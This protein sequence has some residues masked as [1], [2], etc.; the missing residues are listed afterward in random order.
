[1]VPLNKVENKGREAELDGAKGLAWNM[2]RCG[3]A[4]EKYESMRCRI[5]IQECDEV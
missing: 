5:R 2:L 4:T 3:L 1:V